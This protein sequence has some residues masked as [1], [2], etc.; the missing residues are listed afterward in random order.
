M[1]TTPNRCV[2]KPAGYTTGILTSW[3]IFTKG[4]EKVDVFQANIGPRL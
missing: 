3:A 1:K 4:V 2:K